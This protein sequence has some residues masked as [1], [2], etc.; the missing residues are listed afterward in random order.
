M[1]GC[2]G[3]FGLF[4][5]V[6]KV[7]LP[8]VSP[9]SVAGIFQPRPVVP[10]LFP[11]T[12][13]MPATETS[14]TLGRTTFR[15]WPKSL[16]NPQPLDLGRESLREYTVSTLTVYFY[17]TKPG[18]PVELTHTFC[19]FSFDV[20]LLNPHILKPNMEFSTICGQKC[21]C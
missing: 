15:T 13:R 8:N 19:G 4:G 20:S 14:E 16:K 21:M 12:A 2:C 5:G 18:D 17:Y 6:L 7:V 3:F 10:N 9:V 1:I 11:T